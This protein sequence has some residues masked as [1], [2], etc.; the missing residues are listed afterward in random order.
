MIQT[1]MMML[2]F[3]LQNIGTSSL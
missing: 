2:T 3:L 1:S